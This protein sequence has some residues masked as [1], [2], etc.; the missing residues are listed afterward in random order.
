MEIVD[1]H[2]HYCIGMEVLVEEFYEGV[3]PQL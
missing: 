3:G 2:E 1:E